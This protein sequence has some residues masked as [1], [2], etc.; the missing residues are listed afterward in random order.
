MGKRVLVSGYRFSLFLHY[1]KA[2]CLPCYTWGRM[3][4]AH[5]PRYAITI[6][7]VLLGL[8]FL[9]GNVLVFTPV[10][11]ATPVLQA[12]TVTGTPDAAI[13]LTP[14]LPPYPDS[15]DTT[16]ILLLGILLVSVIL[17]GLVWGNRLPRK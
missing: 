10:L 5:L 11:A 9:V 7:L 15:A 3:K 1:T 17:I 6:F 4:S 2:S 12:P 13:S 14:T 16:G 8:T